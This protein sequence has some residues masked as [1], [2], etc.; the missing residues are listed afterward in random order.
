M[1]RDIIWLIACLLERAKSLLKKGR[2]ELG[3]Q[4][5]KVKTCGHSV[6]HELSN[7]LFSGTVVNPI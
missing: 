2:F 5:Q 3:A 7:A 4:R 6:I 1:E